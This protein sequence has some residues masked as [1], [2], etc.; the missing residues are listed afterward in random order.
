MRS[1]IIVNRQDTLDAGAGPR[2][3]TPPAGSDADAAQRGPIREF[4]DHLLS[5]VRQL[6]HRCAQL[7][8]ML[9][10]FAILFATSGEPPRASKPSPST[11]H[12]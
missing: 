5:E 7:E 8:G 6:D 2:E 3:R 10:D 4:L 1:A 12:R 9:H 11:N